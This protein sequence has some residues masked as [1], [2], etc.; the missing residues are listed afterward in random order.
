LKFE[1]AFW[2]N[3]GVYWKFNLK[4]NGEK[5]SFNERLGVFFLHI[6]FDLLIQTTSMGH[7]Q[8]WHIALMIS[9]YYHGH[10]LSLIRWKFFPS[11]E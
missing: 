6:Y 9:C 4:G 11:K 5:C 7:I 2:M 8:L 3:D 10:L 1:A